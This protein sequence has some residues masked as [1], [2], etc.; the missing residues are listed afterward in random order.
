MNSYALDFLKRDDSTPGDSAEDAANETLQATGST[1]C[2]KGSILMQP[3]WSKIQHLPAEFTL[4]HWP[5]A[6]PAANRDLAE[7]SRRTVMLFISFLHS[8]LV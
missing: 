5:V 6:Q 3:T 2:F 4:A 8:P 7:T 1:D